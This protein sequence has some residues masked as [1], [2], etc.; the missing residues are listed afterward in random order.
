MEQRNPKDMFRGGKKILA[1]MVRAGTLPLR[2]LSLAYGADLV[3]GE[4]LIDR[5]MLGATRTFSHATGTWDYGANGR[6]L[7]QA[8]PRDAS[9]T[10]FQMG[11][12]DA[13]R[14]LSVAQLVINDVAGVDVNMGCPKEFSVKGGMGVALMRQPEVVADILTTLRRNLPAKKSVTCKIRLLESVEAT[15]EF[16]RRVEKTGVDAIAVH[17]RTKDQRDH[18]VADWTAVRAIKNAL[19]IPVLLNGDVFSYGDFDKAITD[20]GVDG[21]MSARGALANCSIFGRDY[22][23][24]RIVARKYCEIARRREN[25]YQNTKY[26]V[27]RMLGGVTRKDKQ[28]KELM[29][30]LTQCKTMDLLESTLNADNVGEASE[31]KRRL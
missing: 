14:A 15:V 4:E 19:T 16:C 21:V 7:F 9:R 26:T 27:L 25:N 10:I 29:T 22:E 6:V 20:T 13:Q 24:T 12:N 3:Y 2:E 31:K 1:P 28:Y 8:L 23:D 5:G 30:A 11:T 18:N 17:G